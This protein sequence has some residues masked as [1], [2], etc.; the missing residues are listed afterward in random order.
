ME[1]DDDVDSHEAPRGSMTNAFSTD[2]DD[3]NVFFFDKSDK[4]L[5]ARALMLDENQ[6]KRFYRPLSVLLRPR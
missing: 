1:E 3:E 5:S 4:Q 6:I 2:T